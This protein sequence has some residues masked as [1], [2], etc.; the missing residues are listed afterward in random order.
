[1][2]EQRMD[3]HFGQMDE[4]FERLEAKFSGMRVELNETQETVDFLSSKNAQYEKKPRHVYSQQ[5][6]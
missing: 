5:S 1:M 3:K 6:V 2:F 4:R